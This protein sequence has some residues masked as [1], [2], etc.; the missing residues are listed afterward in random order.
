[1]GGAGGARY[2]GKNVRGRPKAVGVMAGGEVVEC[3]A[4]AGGM[5]APAGAACLAFTGPGGRL[6]N[7]KELVGR[8]ALDE[9]LGAAGLCRVD[10]AGR[11]MPSVCCAP[12]RT[13]FVC[14]LVLGWTSERGL[15]SPGLPILGFEH[16]RELAVEAVHPYAWAVRA[17]VWEEL[18]GVSGGLDWENGVQEFL[19]RVDGRALEVRFLPG[20]K[21]T[22]LEKESDPWCYP[23]RDLEALTGTLGYVRGR[24]GRRRGRVFRWVFKPMFLGRLVVELGVRTA[25]F[26]RK[27]GGRR[28]RE[29]G[30]S[31]DIAR[32]LWADGAG[33]LRAR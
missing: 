5:R 4:G 33:F 20:V 19:D 30:T 24:W 13:D 14:R 8:F 18:G 31:G 27:R 22:G 7:P 11:V 17:E 6:E 21:V 9:R 28:P 2:R 10:E 26:W 1:M 12:T 3:E 15:S 32:F 25:M 16:E 29:L 23:S